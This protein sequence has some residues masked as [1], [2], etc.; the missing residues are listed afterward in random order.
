MY[1]KS[2]KY[3]TVNTK[4]RRS[5]QSRAKFGFI[6]RSN[7][8]LIYIFDQNSWSESESSKQNRFQWLKIRS[9][10]VKPIVFNQKEIIIDQKRSK[11]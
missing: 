6:S 9:K 5:N 3:I 1:Q 10:S 7:G 11:M 2:K 4:L 8:L